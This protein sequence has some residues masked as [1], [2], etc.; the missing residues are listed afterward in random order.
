MAYSVITEIGPV[1]PDFKEEM[2]IILFGPMATPDLRE[3]CVI[4]EFDEVP[5]QALC[6]GKVLKLGEQI[7]TI[8][9]VGSEANKNFTELGHVSI[10]FRDNENGLLPGA[11][12]VEPE[13][14][15]DLKVGDKIH[16]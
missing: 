12:L 3:I 9:Y 4:H 2:V 16:F 5:E 14:F 11:V 13:C 8:K 6:I 7:Y 10:Y 1:V 15:P